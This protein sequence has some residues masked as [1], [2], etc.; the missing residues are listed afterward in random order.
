MYNYESA[1]EHSS[2]KMQISISAPLLSDGGLSTSTFYLKVGESFIVKHVSESGA[3][4]TYEM[5]V[6]A[7]GI[8]FK[9]VKGM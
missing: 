6:S 3:C 4:K 9:I 5:A 7:N 8:G 2:K 1:E